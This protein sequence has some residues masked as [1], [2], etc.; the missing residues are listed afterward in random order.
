M[1]HA[2][3]GV[4][5]QLVA[6]LKAQLGISPFLDKIVENACNFMT[7]CLIYIKISASQLLCKYEGECVFRF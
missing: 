6:V 2:R 3:R 1:G 5:L 7:S 4:N